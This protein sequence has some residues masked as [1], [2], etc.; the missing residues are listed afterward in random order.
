MHTAML[1]D[2]ALPSALAL[3]LYSESKQGCPS[4]PANLQDSKWANYSQFQ[5]AAGAKPTP[6]EPWQ[7][8]ADSEASDGAAS[9]AAADGA[10]T[11][12]ELRRGNTSLAA[13]HLDWQAAQALLAAANA[14][15][16]RVAAALAS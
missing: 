5:M 9:G 3:L 14:T 11:G 16:D 10:A 4:L 12:T 1:G 13:L 2:S 15:I 7:R 8:D 6:S